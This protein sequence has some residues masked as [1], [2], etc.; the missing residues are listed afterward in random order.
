MSHSPTRRGY[1]MLVNASLQGGYMRRAPTALTSSWGAAFLGRVSKDGVR[2]HPSRRAPRRER[3]L[4]MTALRLKR[5]ARL[6]ADQALVPPSTV[7]LAP[8]I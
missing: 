2:D 4:G 3:S 5:V 8:V 7:R 1:W 6:P